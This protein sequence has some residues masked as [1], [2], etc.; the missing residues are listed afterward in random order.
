MLLCLQNPNQINGHNQNK[1]MTATEIS[2]Q[3]KEVP[4]TSRELQSKHKE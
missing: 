1:I 4:E 3:Q 2:E